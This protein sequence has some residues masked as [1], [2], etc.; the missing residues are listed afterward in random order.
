[1]I[2]E[3]LLLNN[4]EKKAIKE[5][6]P[7]GVKIRMLSANKGK[8]LVVQFSAE[9]DNEDVAKTLSK[10]DDV[11]RKE[12]HVI[13]LESGCAAYFNKR[14]YP[15]IN[16]FENKL[17]KLL[18]LIS[19]INEND[20]A[21][22]NIENLETKNLGDIFS[23]LFIDKDFIKQVKEKV[24]G[25]QQECFTKEKV[26]SSIDDI[27]E[28]TFWDKL[29]GKDTVPTLRK[30][31]NDI[32]SY[33]NVVMHS[34]PFVNWNQFR[35]I[36]E[37]YNTVNSELDEALYNVE[38]VESKAPSRPDFNSTLEQALK[39]QEEWK[40]YFAEILQPGVAE[41]QS[42]RN[43]YITNPTVSEYQKQIA[44]Y[45]KSFAANSELLKLQEQMAEISKQYQI[46]PM[47]KAIQEQSKLLADVKATV[48]SALQKLQELADMVQVNKTGIPSEMLKLQKSLSALGTSFKN[49]STWNRSSR[50]GGSFNE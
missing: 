31:F 26:L 5:T 50:R 41:M 21:N 27:E 46:S 48:P 6:K 29:L 24:K 7:D 3:Y 34:Q 9:G 35:E 25:I 19:A 4:T 49:L 8:C 39:S 18:Y 23:M 28:N 16:N 36:Q 1:M 38:V 14:L 2:Q 44:E 32:R 30:R 11:I 42:I 43:L 12:F 17:R 33:R 45:F 13:I 10:L 15:L 22:N 37:L 40:K 20:S 47:V